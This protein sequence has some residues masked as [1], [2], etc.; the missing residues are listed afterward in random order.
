MRTPAHGVKFAIN[1][2]VVFHDTWPCLVRH[3]KHLGCWKINA[4]IVNC[5]PTA[6]TTSFK[7]PV[8][9]SGILE[10]GCLCTLGGLPLSRYCVPL[11]VV[12][13]IASP[14]PQMSSIIEHKP[15]EE[16]ALSSKHGHWFHQ[17]PSA[18]SFLSTP[19]HFFPPT[20]NAHFYYY[21]FS[22]WL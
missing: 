12:L 7:L 17:Q 19:I 8:S 9:A 10:V 2:L 21:L 13:E 22:Y 14:T 4:P 6:M 1:I 11:T 5:T 16:L 3:Q 18:S 20:F 15:K